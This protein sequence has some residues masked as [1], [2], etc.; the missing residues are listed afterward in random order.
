MGR[1]NAD[2]MDTLDNEVRI[3]ERVV[4]TLLGKNVVPPLPLNVLT[5]LQIIESSQS[6]TV[7][8]GSYG[9]LYE[10]LIKASLSATAGGGIVAR[11][12][13]AT[14]L[15]VVAYSMFQR[16]QAVLSEA[17]FQKAE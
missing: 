11:Q 2:E 8:D 7:T 1:E 16:E 9:A 4:T 12:T 14:Y 15:S 5:L 6:H 10:V 13:K 3:A 17:G